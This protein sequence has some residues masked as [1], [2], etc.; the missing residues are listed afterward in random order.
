MI[1]T[2][3]TFLFSVGLVLTLAG[4]SCNQT[5]STNTN[6]N[7]TNLNP[8]INTPV[9]TPVTPVGQTIQNDPGERDLMIRTSSDGEQFGTASVFEEAAGVPSVIRTDD[10]RLVA[11]FQAFPEDLIAAKISTDDGATWSD[12]ELIEIEG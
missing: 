3:K 8:S 9:N 12:R 10:D 4:A 5:T 2:T 1:N 6:A 7:T 11:A